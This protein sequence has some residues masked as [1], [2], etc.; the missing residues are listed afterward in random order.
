MMESALIQA[1]ISGLIGG[2][3]TG[4]AAWAAIRVEI[5]YLRRDVDHAHRRL[6]TCKISK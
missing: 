5:K 4:V 1:V 2:T 3:M 6:D